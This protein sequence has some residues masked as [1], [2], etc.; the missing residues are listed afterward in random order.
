MRVLFID[1]DLITAEWVSIFLNSKNIETRTV[2]SI[3]AAISCLNEWIPDLIV[4]DLNLRGQ[5]AVELVEYLARG[6]GMNNIP[7]IAVTGSELDTSEKEKFR[8]YLK[9]PVQAES[10]YQLILDLAGRVS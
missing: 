10:L 8:G 9:K 4:S 6:N 7:V 3:P 5:H 1:D 2:D